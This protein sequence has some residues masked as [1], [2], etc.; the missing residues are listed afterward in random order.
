MKNTIILMLLLV[1]VGIGSASYGKESYDV[2]DPNEKDTRYA[3]YDLNKDGNKEEIRLVVADF[4]DPS[5]D[6]VCVI[7]VKDGENTYA[8][9]IRID[10]VTSC[11]LNIIDIHPSVNAYIGIGHHAGGHTYILSLYNITDESGTPQ[12]KH[13][14]DFGSDRP[15][16]EVKDFD[17]DDILEI[18]VYSR[19]WNGENPVKDSVVDVYKYGD[20]DAW[21][22]II[23]EERE[24]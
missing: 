18:F 14:R 8:K 5:I 7:E 12:I 16:I 10:T 20:K 23:V 24:Q 11:D 4:D 17:G 3:K 21:E 1:C 22:K 19:N 13:I 15:R 6:A 2:Y 9:A